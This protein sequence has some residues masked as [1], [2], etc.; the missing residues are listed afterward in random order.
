[1]PGVGNAFLIL[2]LVMCIYAILAVEFF[3]Y[4]DNPKFTSARG[5]LLYKT[6]GQEYFGNFARSLYTLFQVLTG[7]SWSE[8]IGRPLMEGG[9]WFSTMFFVSFI[10]INAVVLINV[11]VAVLLE[12]MVD[13]EE[14]DSSEKEELDEIEGDMEDLKTALDCV[15]AEVSMTRSFLHD[16]LHAIRATLQQLCEAQG[17]HVHLPA[18]PQLPPVPLP[19]P[20]K[21][22]SVDASEGERARLGSGGDGWT[23]DTVS[24]E[25]E[26]AAPANA[27]STGSSVIDMTGGPVGGGGIGETPVILMSTTPPLDSPL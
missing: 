13:P 20:R 12:K 3:K 23:G 10:L 1:M 9:G 25:I 26:L 18:P 15:H 14:E 19:A 16:E 17:L 27:T 2:L 6:H 5:E 7:D 22:I 4:F 24:S 11:V 21:S 8:A